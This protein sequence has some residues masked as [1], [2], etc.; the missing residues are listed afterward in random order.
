M[1]FL[2]EI[3][4][5]RRNSLPLCVMQRD[6]RF[7]E[8]GWAAAV[9]LC[10]DYWTSPAKLGDLMERADESAEGGNR[11]HYYLVSAAV[12]HKK[13]I[14]KVV[15][16]LVQRPPKPRLRAV[17]TLGVAQMLL[18][19]VAEKVVDS[20]VENAKRIV[21]KAE[22]GFLNAV[23]RRVPDALKLYTENDKQFAWGNR[24]SHPDWL[25]KT[26]TEQWGPEDTLALLEWNQAGHV[27]VYVRIADDSVLPSIQ[28]FLEST[29]WPSFYRFTGKSWDKIVEALK[30]G[31]VYVQDPAT[32]IAIDL[33]APKSGEIVLDLCAAPGGKSRLIA[34][35]LKSGTVVAVDQGNYR[36]ER[37]KENLALVGKEVDVHVLGLDVLE[38]KSDDFTQAK[39]PAQYE[40]V[41]L[42]APCSSTGVLRRRPDAKWR[43]VPKEIAQVAKLQS[44]L[45]NSTAKCV[46]PGG[47]LVYST[48]SV[49][50]SEN[51]QQIE[52]FLK[53]HSDFSL[54]KS[55]M[56]YPWQVKHDGGGAFLLKRKA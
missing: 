47:R 45:L 16:S 12:R 25:I 11:S 26:W 8:K 44:A 55:I 7:F 19:P 24:Y 15:D 17:L 21:S 4:W 31:K 42:D 22:V 6:K 34:D 2:K 9:Q 53:R 1:F 28:E 39:V 38:L 48:C 35:Q 10:E 23:L 20:V 50:T 29:E 27:P 56:S 46:A 40:A 49:E 51:T 36:L 52:A 30:A 43:L 54:E 32:R 14:D 13:L 41:L 33:L 37:L 3:D 5:Q 18:E